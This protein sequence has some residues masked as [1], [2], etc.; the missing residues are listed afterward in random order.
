MILS[1]RKFVEFTH[2]IQVNIVFVH[3]IL[4]TNPK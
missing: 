2:N 4:F 3:F 1:S